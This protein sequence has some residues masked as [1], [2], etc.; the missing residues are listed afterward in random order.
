MLHYKVTNNLETKA[1]Q[2][3]VQLLDNDKL[4]V[5][6]TETCYG[7]G[8]DAT[9]QKAVEKVFRLKQREFTKP[10][11]VAVSSIKMAN[12][13]AKV[14]HRA[15]ILFESFLPG[16]LTIILESR[17]ILPSVLNT[18]RP[19]IGIRCPDHPI[20]LQIIR[21]LGRPIT[22]TSAN[23]SGHPTAYTVNDVI[24]QLGDKITAIIDVGQI[25]HGLASTVI[26]L[27]TVPPRLLREGPIKENTILDTIENF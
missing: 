15:R 7:L 11:H 21:A 12:C 19:T 9:R 22:T 3:V 8:G 13:Y 26:D 20:P 24:S 10:I 17:G 6:P 14:D 23:L 25:S 2:N 1:L 27:T 16:P 5:Y 18:N 4:I